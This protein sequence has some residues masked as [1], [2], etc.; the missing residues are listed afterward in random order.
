MLPDFF[1]DFLNR[2]R[3][4]SPVAGYRMSSLL[5]G[6]GFSLGIGLTLASPAQA[7]EPSPGG[8]P[9]FSI[10]TANNPKPSNPLPPP[11]PPGGTATVNDQAV[12][13]IPPSTKVAMD[14][15]EAPLLD[16]VKYM[17]RV[18]CKNF[19][20]TEDLKGQV[21]IISHTQVTAA[22]AYEAFLSALEVAGYTTVE[23][24]RVIKLVPTSEAANSPLRVYE[25]DTLPRG[26]DQYVTQILQL[27]NV[28]AS[29]IS[30]IVKEVG[31]SKIRVI[32]YNPTNTL[33]I[34][35]SA[36]NIRR[37]MSIIMQLDV[38]APRSSIEVIPLRYATAVDVERILEEV[39]GVS[40]TSGASGGS[41]GATSAGGAASKRTA[42]GGKG[43]EAPAPAAGGSATSV[44]SDSAYISKIIADERTNSLI[45]MANEEAL[46]NIRSLIERIDIDIDPFSRSTIHVIYLE[47]ASAEDVASVLSSLGSSGS[48]GSRPSSSSSS[49]GS[50]STGSTR[51]PSA[52]G[53]RGGA[54][55]TG[56]NFGG[57]PGGK[58]YV[59]GGAPG[60]VGGV[61]ITTALENV[62]IAADENTNSLVIIASQDEFQILKSVVDRLDIPRRQ[63]FVEAVVV[64]V[65]DT[66]E[67]SLGLGLHGGGGG[68]AGNFS[69]LSGQMG[70][71]SLAL[72]TSSLLSGLAVG[73]LGPAIDVPILDASTGQATTL[74]V[75][76]FGIALKALAENSQVDILSDP[77]IL[78][79]DNEE[80]TI[81]VG[82][83]VPFPVSSGFDTNRNP[84][85]SYQRED[86]GITLTVR[87]QINE[88]NYVTL[89]VSLQVAEVEG[90]DNSGLDVATAGF[91][92]STREIENVIVVKDNQ[93]I[94]LGG[95][96]GTTSSE[97]STKIPILGDIPLFG[98]LF[99]SKS[100][101]DRRTNL[102]IFLTPHVISEP[103]DLE[104]VY[105][106]KE[107]Q[108]EEFLRRFYGKSAETQDQ[109]LRELL[110]Y[111]LNLVDEPSVYRTKSEPSNSD[112]DDV[113]SGGDTG[114]QMQP[115][116]AGGTSGA[117][118]AGSDTP[119]ADP[120]PAG[121][122]Q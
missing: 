115:V 104:E 7:Q 79:M 34:T 13:C 9:G 119:P 50:R 6:L 87:P 107:A 90:G 113:G 19:I 49:T 96:I 4:I 3:N 14:F 111:S 21:T 114:G 74:S 83:N 68:S 61:G 70:A 106:I 122:G 44:G 63:V 35:D 36:Y 45:V 18:M 112:G 91:I 53:N 120:A 62:K 29:E 16:V 73:V 15:N 31:G 1:A 109:E 33:I 65:A 37:V 75:P 57:P 27:N 41:S 59:P 60:D 30:S 85:I 40:V 47:H 102:L 92:T 71:S 78:V 58:P 121:G 17:A 38:A 89:E 101:T 20:L 97:T 24:G 88:S 80:A 5:L 23:V 52:G 84:I 12:Q 82:R 108:R 32:A 118:G 81:S 105:R 98:V 28:E 26:S 2:S 56:G 110:R 43:G 86:V 51:A 46:A 25:G 67:N 94:V 22:E 48:S 8:K 64:E 76:V 39:Y 103:G 66:E 77:S 100:T 55:S 42:R 93:T 69:Y 10:P 72:D 116:G 54:G 11:P 99:R 117:G 95:L